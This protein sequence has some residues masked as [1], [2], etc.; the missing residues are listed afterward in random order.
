MGQFDYYSP[1]EEREAALFN[2]S[3]TMG[4]LIAG[5][6]R[7]FV[8]AVGAE[9]PQ[10]A[11]ILSDRDCWY[12]NPFYKGPAQRHPEDYDFEDDTDA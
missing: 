10:A 9:R 5:A 6:E 1:E 2:D 4:E 8:A 3:L 7:Q 12:P 11:W